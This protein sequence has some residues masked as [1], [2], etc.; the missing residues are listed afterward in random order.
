MKTRIMIALTAL[1]PTIASAGIWDRIPE[2]LDNTY[3]DI[4]GDWCSGKKYL[5]GEMKDSERLYEG[6]QALDREIA[7]L[8][9]V[10]SKLMYDLENHIE[11]N[12]ENV[13]DG[14]EKLVAKTIEL[15][16]QTQSDGFSNLSYDGVELRDKDEVVARFR[17]NMA[18]YRA[19]MD[20]IVY[21]QKTVLEYG[22]LK[23]R[24]KDKANE[25]VVL[26]KSFEE[27]SDPRSNNRS[28]S[29][30]ETAIQSG[31]VAI[32]N[33]EELKLTYTNMSPQE[34]FR[35]AAENRATH[36]IRDGQIEAFMAS[37]DRSKL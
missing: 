13:N 27:L 21:L 15:C 9:D 37:C 1:I 5:V 7:Q 20:A 18:S 32:K 19:S 8:H 26:K 22:R 4:V 33:S 34:L 16:H 3:D 24:I 17:M 31:C 23:K 2:T 14:M 11:R 12:V 10:S 35:D 6:I 28:S 30:L 36:T 29:N 25:L